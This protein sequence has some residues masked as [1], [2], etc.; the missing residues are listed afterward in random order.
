MDGDTLN[1]YAGH[2]RVIACGHD[3]FESI[4]NAFGSESLA[5]YLA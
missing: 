2:E 5:I 4:E 1:S 3:R